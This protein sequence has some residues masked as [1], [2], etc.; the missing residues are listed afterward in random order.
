MERVNFLWMGL[1]GFLE[2]VMARILITE[3]SYNFANA[4]ATFNCNNGFFHEICY[5][6]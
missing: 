1:G 5:H 3:S 6:G 4:L 2:G